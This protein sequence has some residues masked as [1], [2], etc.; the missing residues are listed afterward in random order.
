MI[1][2]VNVLKKFAMFALALTLVFGVATTAFA[3][4]SPTKPAQK[5]PVTKDNV[6]YAIS[7]KT[8]KNIYKTYKSGVAHLKKFRIPVR[9]NAILPTKM[10][11]KGVSYKVT[12]IRTDAFNQNK[13][14]K[15]ILIKKNYNLIKKYAFRGSKITIIKFGQNK[16]PKIEKKAFKNCKVKKIK[17]SKKMSKK[18]YKKLKKLCKRAGFKGKF[19]RY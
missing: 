18:N 6:K 17:V 3:A 13:K 5:K 9:K 2:M 11:Y 1:P 12:C 8:K 19:V 7:S 16:V 14:L 10:K 15:K 4:S